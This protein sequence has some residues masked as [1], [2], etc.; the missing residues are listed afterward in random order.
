MVQKINPVLSQPFHFKH[1]QFI[2]PF[3]QQNT[4]SSFFPF[5]SRGAGA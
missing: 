5:F 3:F 4:I 1:N 2:F